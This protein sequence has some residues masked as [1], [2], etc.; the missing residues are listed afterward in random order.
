MNLFLTWVFDPPHSRVWRTNA[1]LC[2]SSL[3]RGT[4]N[5]DILVG[6]S[7]PEP[8]FPVARTGV[9]EMLDPATNRTGVAYCHNQDSGSGHRQQNEFR[10]ARLRFAQF[11][12]SGENSGLIAD[13]HQY[14][15]IL[16]ADADC[17]AL[18][19]LDHLLVGGSEILFAK[20]GPFVDPGFIAVRGSIFAKFIFE[21]INA[22]EARPTEP[23]LLGG[24][25]FKNAWRTKL[26][27]RG[28]VISIARSNASIEDMLNTS[29]VHLDGLKHSLK[30]RLSF[31]LHMMNV[32][33]D[34]D[35]VF[36]DMLES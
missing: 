14:E 27:E 29:V 25:I 16:I 19:N 34:K 8:L 30:T 13:W 18:R 11:A 31:A 3:L 7:F 23:D 33:G 9:Y 15:W 6:R 1:K 5:G 24:I 32:Y 20:H 35:G 22:L 10:C 17:V 28:E 4:W 26:F 36:F 12:G 21:W 2:V